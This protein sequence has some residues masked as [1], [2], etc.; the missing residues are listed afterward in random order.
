MPIY[1]TAGAGNMSAQA[2]AAVAQRGTPS[3][4][5]LDDIFG[6][7]M[8]TPDGETVFLGE[9][10]QAPQDPNNT[11][12]VM[13]SGEGNDVHISAAKQDSTGHYVP[14]PQGGGLPTT[15]LLDASKPAL[16]MGSAPGQAVAPTAQQVPF[17][18]AP[19]ERH[20]LQYAAPKRKRS[21][22]SDR[23]MSEQQKSDRRY[24]T[25]SCIVCF[26]VPACAALDDVM[27]AGWVWVDTCVV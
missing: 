21:S 24:V 2:A 26:V 14:V 22:R 18:K 27:G 20:H 15:N 10:G 12:G 23:K 8:F 6:D 16:C 7:V 17:K 5:N 25:V 3:T 4:L 19:Q 13:L 9:Q 1:T 11:G